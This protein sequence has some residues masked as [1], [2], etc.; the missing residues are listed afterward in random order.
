MAGGGT[1]QL[2]SEAP[3]RRTSQ[4]VCVRASGALGFKALGARGFS[5]SGALGFIIWF[6]FKVFGFYSS[7]SGLSVCFPIKSP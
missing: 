1:R 3:A 5:D 6:R 4:T 2:A 7:V